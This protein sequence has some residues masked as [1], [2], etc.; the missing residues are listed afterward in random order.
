MDNDVVFTDVI[1][2]KQ[3]NKFISLWEELSDSRKKH[4]FSV[5]ED[6]LGH[7]PD[8]LRDIKEIDNAYEAMTPK[9]KGDLYDYYGHMFGISSPGF[10]ILDS[11]A[12][13]LKS[14]ISF[15]YTVREYFYIPAEL[16]FKR[17]FK[18]VINI[19]TWN[20]FSILWDVATC[21][22]G[23]ERNKRPYYDDVNYRN[24]NKNRLESEISHIKNTTQ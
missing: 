6:I 5:I 19:K 21:E 1:D 18:G 24:E 8:R 12:K 13:A 7:V 22:K 15:L 2:L 23:F 20:I 16:D 10:S 4:T 14:I 17:V 11:D 9:H 3:A